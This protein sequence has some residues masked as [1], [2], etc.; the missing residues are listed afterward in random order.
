M[1]GWH[2]LKYVVMIGML[3][4]LILLSLFAYLNFR[5]VVD[6]SGHRTASAEQVTLM[7]KTESELNSFKA[8]MRFWINNT[9]ARLD[10]LERSK[11][12]VQ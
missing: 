3:L 1:I 7:N 10:E 6:F 4:W 11:G 2:T 5:T 12:G 8:R 9:E